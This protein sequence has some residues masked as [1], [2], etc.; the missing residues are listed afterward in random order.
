MSVNGISSYIANS[1][2][3]GNTR[4]TD[5]LRSSAS[6]G[7]I[8]RQTR[9][10]I[11]S[12]GSTEYLAKTDAAR[13]DF[14]DETDNSGQTSPLMKAKQLFNDATTLHKSSV[15]LAVSVLSGGV[16]G[17]EL[18]VLVSD[19]ADSYN[20]TEKTLLDT[21]SRVASSALS[22]TA[23]AYSAA[24]S[25]AGITVGED[26]SLDVDESVLKENAEYAKT[27]FSGN[28][29]FGGKTVKKSFELAAAA[30]I[31]GNAGTYTR[32]GMFVRN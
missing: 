32:N 17:D 24:L 1:T 4:L 31:Y 11:S 30:E 29:S 23:K 26:G 25:S 20:Q 27:L 3:N 7:T 21:G 13:T 15:K 22:S 2:Y 10:L 14:S 5:L 6:S 16:S 12:A 19:F 18:A 9:K 8:S 28:Y